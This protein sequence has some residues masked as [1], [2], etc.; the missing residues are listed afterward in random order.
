MSDP[1]VKSIIYTK[2]AL[3]QSLLIRD[4]LKR[5]F[6]EKEATAFYNFIESFEQVVKYYPKL[7]N[8]AS[9]GLNIRRAVLSKELSI[10][11]RINRNLIE[12]IAI[13]DNRCDFES[14]IK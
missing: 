4:Y 12:V 11:Y 9:K 14:W 10:Y 1:K 7:Y 5:N 8:Q 6:T 2:R 3:K 13:L